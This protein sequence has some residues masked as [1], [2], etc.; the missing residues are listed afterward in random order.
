MSSDVARAGAR[1]IAIDGI[2]KRYTLGMSVGRFRYRSLR[3]TVSDATTRQVRRLRGTRSNGAT[4]EPSPDH[5]W[6]LRDVSFSVAQGE[7][8]GII[9]RNGA[10]KSTLLK[11]LS[12]ITKPTDPKST[13]LNSSHVKSS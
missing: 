10:G 5:I 3:E 9:G 13:R 4:R 7:V 11:I 1:A 2:G 12:R 6:A 8:V